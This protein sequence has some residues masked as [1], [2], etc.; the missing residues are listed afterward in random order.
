MNKFK[1]GDKVCLGAYPHF[2]G[3]VVVLTSFGMTIQ[4]DGGR[5]F[6]YLDFKE[7]KEGIYHRAELKEKN[8]HPYTTLFI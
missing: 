2:T 4:W 3:K 7:A 8:N 1:V 5:A 6:E